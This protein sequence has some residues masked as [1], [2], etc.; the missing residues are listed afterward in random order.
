MRL[1][2]DQVSEFNEKPQ[3]TEGFINGGFFV[4]NTQRFFQSLGDDPRTVL[5]QEPMK[6]LAEQGELVAYRHP[7]FWQP[8]DTYREYTLLNDLWARGS[9]P[10]KTWK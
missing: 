10:W 9:A 2:G 5:E 6:A 8:M 1:A 7:G 3:T 4:C